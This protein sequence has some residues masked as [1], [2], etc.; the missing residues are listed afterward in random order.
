MAR[1]CQG[2]SVRIRYTGRL[3]DGTVFDSTEDA[4][5]L[6]FVAGDGE[7]IEGVDLAVI[8]MEEGEHKSLTIEPAQGF[9]DRDSALE[10]SVART[11]LPDEV[12]VGD[13]LRA[14]NGEEETYV[15]VRELSEESAIIDANHPL[16]GKTLLF[17]LEMIAITPGAT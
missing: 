4:E 8:G 2:D 9:G 10:Q 13:R 11:E 12:Q 15:W 1:V 14:M 5:P 17:D 7:V 16:A 3:A 6:E